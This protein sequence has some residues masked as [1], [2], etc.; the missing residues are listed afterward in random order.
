MDARTKDFMSSETLAAPRR[1]G[2][3]QGATIVVAAFLPIMA[4][5]SLAP[6]IPRIIQH[7]G[8]GPAVTLVPLMV[9]APGLLIALFSPLMGWL[10]DR[11]GRRPILLVATFIYG[12]LGVAPLLFSSLREIFA[13]R[14][15]LGVCEA[16]ILTATNALIGDYFDPAQRRLWLTVQGVVGPI[17]GTTVILTGGAVTERLWNGAFAIY[18]VAFVVFLAMVLFIFEPPRV[19]RHVEA[20]DQDATPFPWRDVTAFSAVTLFSAMLYYVGIVQA[21]LAFGAVGVASPKMLGMLI[22]L[23]SMGVPVGAILFW[24]VARRASRAT[25][26]AC[27]LSLLGAGMVGVGLSHN[28]QTATTLAVLQQIGSGMTIPALIYWATSVLDGRHRGRG[29]GIWNSAFFFGQFLSPLMFSFVRIYA[30]GVLQTFVALGVM[31][32]V[33]GA[34]AICLGRAAPRGRAEGRVT[35]TRKDMT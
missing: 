10:S 19:A 29:M 23:A 30:G 34:V 1:A 15:G 27:F 21:G 31:A 2:I 35:P 28:Y 12:C 32:L 20:H 16:A 24:L 18:G 25:L 33:G 3:G 22:S 11:Y 8:G 9:T 5:V 7:F 26:V 4:I 13:A 17:F 6:A 14:L